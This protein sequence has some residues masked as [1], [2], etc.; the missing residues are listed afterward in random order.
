MACDEG[1]WYRAMVT[2]VMAGEMV[3]VELV[4][5]ASTF[6]TLKENLRKISPELMKQTVVAVSC[7]LDSWV[8]E[9]KKIAMDKWGKKMAEMVEQYSEVQV[10]VV[11]QLENGQFKVKFSEL[12]KKLKEV[13]VKSRA[14]MFKDRLRKK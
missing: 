2:E 9:D 6:T 13:E 1:T 11:G 7:C 14:E 5:L 10:E 4:D 8:G 3:N 12:E